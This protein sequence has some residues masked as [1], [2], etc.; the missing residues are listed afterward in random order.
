VA[1]VVSYAQ[2]AKLKAAQ[3]GKKDLTPTAF[4]AR[5]NRMESVDKR[6]AQ[7]NKELVRL[8]YI[9]RTSPD[10]LERERAVVSALDLRLE[11]ISLV[12]TIS[13]EL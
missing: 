5:V 3:Q 9:L 11:A 10:Y 13:N 6:L 2:F 7:I 12:K 4:D 8:D 1:V